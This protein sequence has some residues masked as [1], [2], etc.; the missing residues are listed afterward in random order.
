MKNRLILALLFGVRFK[1]AVSDRVSA[2]KLE[3]FLWQQKKSNVYRISGA[4]S[5]G[6]PA[7]IEGP[8]RLTFRC[9]W[10][11]LNLPEKA[12]RNARPSDAKKKESIQKA[13]LAKGAKRLCLEQLY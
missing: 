1:Q 13:E 12:G 10:G 9:I 3:S 5:G 2:L 4:R 7:S 11:S 6:V 8:S